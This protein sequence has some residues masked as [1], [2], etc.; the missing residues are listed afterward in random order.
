V[1]EPLPFVTELR[2]AGVGQSTSPTP[3]SF[4]SSANARCSAVLYPMS[5]RS[6]IE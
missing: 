6:P 5:P 3:V 4:R 2:D 1:V